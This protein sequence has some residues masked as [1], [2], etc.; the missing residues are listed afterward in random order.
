MPHAAFPD[1]VLTIAAGGITETP[2]EGVTCLAAADGEVLVGTRS[3]LVR[4]DAGGPTQV[5]DGHIT[6]VARG[7]DEWW[8]GTEPSVVYRSPD[9]EN[10][11]ELPDLTTLPSSDRW[12]FPPRPDTHHVR[13]LAADPN[14]ETRWYV[15]IEAGALVRTDDGG[16]SWR[17]RVPGAR[18]DTHELATHPDAPGR[19]YC[20][21]GDGYAESTD[22]GDSWHYPQEGLDERYCW[23]VAVDPA[24]PETRLLA[25]ARSAMQA[26][27]AGVSS[28]YRKRGDDPW[29]RVDA[30]PHGE[31]CYRAVVRADGPG[32]FLALSNRGLFRSEDAGE[33][34][35]E[36][37]PG[38]ALPDAPPAG[39]A[40][41]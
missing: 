19:L 40:V 37:V 14:R 41:D 16:Q 15:A 38:D 21:A 17:D 32:T 31:G 5:L 12:A 29:E 11:T 36:T 33:T 7:D 26:H 10:W 6:A 27:R 28:V 34:W 3:G 23:S 4:L 8:A 18:Y 25:S 30:L 2:L 24:D 9:T 39:L 13:W 22:G 1:R 35:T 20:A